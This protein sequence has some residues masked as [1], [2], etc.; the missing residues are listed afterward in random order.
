MSIDD[1]RI[2]EYVRES[3]DYLKDCRTVLLRGIDPSDAK[4]LLSIPSVK[5][6]LI[7]KDLGVHVKYDPDYS[8]D[9][10]KDVHA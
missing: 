7:F 2:T 10:F 3:Y 4:M 5:A 8:K 6:I 9:I 1:I